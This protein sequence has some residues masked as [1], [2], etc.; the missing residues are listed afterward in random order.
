MQVE[1]SA[2]VAKY[3]TLLAD[4]NHDRI[5]YMLA[6][7]LLEE[8]K[9]KQEVAITKLKDEIRLLNENLSDLELQI[10]ER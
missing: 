8:E 6:V 7:G 5:C 10:A 3:K 9:G 4:A 2:I 1:L